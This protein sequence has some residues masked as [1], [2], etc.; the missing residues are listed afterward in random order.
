[1]FRS[2]DEHERFFLR[3]CA[4][5]EQMSFWEAEIARLWGGSPRLSAL[6]GEFDLN[7]RAE[8]ADG[9]LSVV[10]IMAAG[11]PRNDVAFQ[12]DMLGHI[13]ASCDLPVPK[14][15]PALDGCD[16]V[17]ARDETGAERIIWRISMCPG[18]PYYKAA[19]PGQLRRDTGRMMAQ[20]H[21]A[22]KDFRHDGLD[23]THKW[24]L[25]AAHWI[26]EHLDVF[27]DPAR[28]DQIKAILHWYETIGQPLLKSLPS[29]AIHNDI[30][31]HNI[32]VDHSPG[33]LPHLS[34]LIDFGD[35][36]YNPRL[37]DLAIAAAY[38]CMQVERP[39]E[40]LAEIIEGY[41]ALAPLSEPEIDAL[42]PLMQVRLAVSVTNS[43]LQKQQRPDDPYVVVSEKPA[44]D[45]LDKA[46][47]LDPR[48]PAERLR[49]AAGLPPT[50][51][52]IATGFTPAPMFKADLSTAS[53]LDLTP[54]NTA[55]S[56]DSPEPDQDQLRHVVEDA[57]ARHGAALGRYSETR[58]IYT[59]ELFGD[60]SHAAG[61]RRTIHIGVDIFLPA[62]TKVHAPFPG[63]IASASYYPTEHDYGGVVV[64]EHDLPDG[65]KF[66]ALYG[67]LNKSTIDDLSTGQRIESG[68]A[69]AELG[70]YHEN[71]QWPP[72]L[73]LQISQADAPDE[74]IWPGVVD[75][76][77]REH[78]ERLY[79]DPS[80][81][82]SDRLP[83]LNA[84]G[85]SNAELIEARQS[86][87][88]SNLKLSYGEPIHMIR[89]T[90][91]YLIDAHGR[92]YLDG[93]N[94]VPHVG[95][96]HPHVVGAVRD[97]MGRLNTNTRYLSE[98][99]LAYSQN[100]LRY[101]PDSFDTCLF[102]NSGT[103]ANELALRLARAFTGK[104]D[105]AVS[106]H[107]YHGISQ[108]CIDISHYKFAR[109]GGA[110]QKDWVHVLPVPN[111]FS[112][113]FKGD[114]AGPAY[115]RQA[116]EILHAAH[117]NGDGLAACIIEPFP[118]VGG[119]VIPPEGYLSG[120]IDA[121]HETGALMVFD[122]VQ[123]G[124]GRLG[125]DV[126]AFQNQGVTP[127]IVVLGKPMGNGHPMG[128]VI[129]RREI[130]DRFA[131]GMEFF[132]TFGGSN[133]S[134]AA[135]QA[136]LDVLEAENLRAQVD[137]VGQHMLEGLK[138]IFARFAWPSDVRGIGLFLGVEILTPEGKPATDLVDHIVNAMKHN[139]VLIGSDGPDDNVLKIRPPICF[140][141]DDSAF[142]LNALDAVIRDLGAGPAH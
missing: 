140:T 27:D 83:G 68:Q 85:K 56:C 7:L 98:S 76:D 136:V 133:L 14:V 5:T 28:R 37:A 26:G 94:N 116:R 111:P 67:H 99:Y 60:I 29:H 92:R 102:V 42:W 21:E 18:V 124:L 25:C 81:L 96:T 20:M 78:W 128:A 31:D 121:V 79:P 63:R 131:T 34:G 73:H 87:A 103:E 51:R 33:A 139:R 105:V 120:L 74:A 46:K 16:F 110:G 132:S 107:G 95:H 65:A 24:E 72:H 70:D 113:Q 6:Y 122:E 53:V 2:I 4:M 54:H 58:L 135:G 129:T 127:D 125:S 43:G 82:V 69:F 22:L 39:V 97:Q 64:I 88:L 47:A 138:Q 9:T 123:T 84:R 52:N 101:F 13:A 104:H 141:L 137:L 44:L 115:A 49:A 75:A 50:P 86:M 77:E 48:Y 3:G 36:L 23:R 45:L 91:A 32:F 40:A 130:A 109:K 71:G 112:G 62:G 134:C 142:F 38:L 66:K 30:N 1:M 19:K 41:V 17:T 119:Q 12:T 117:Q 11:C 93:Y 118:S 10:K 126:W 8:E 61:R 90:K 89:G 114:G 100:L 57:L 55:L 106:Q 59:G 35:A 80:W 15:L 108:L